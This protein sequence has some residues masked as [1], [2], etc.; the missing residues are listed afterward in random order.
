[1]G[2]W[3]KLQTP[4]LNS[5]P[6]VMDSASIFPLH[7]TLFFEWMED[8]FTVKTIFFQATQVK[9]HPQNSG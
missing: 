5:I 7:K 8:T 4:E 2:K 9:P 6:S 3:L 1:M